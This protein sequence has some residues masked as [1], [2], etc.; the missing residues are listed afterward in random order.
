MLTTR[1]LMFT[2][3]L[4]L[5]LLFACAAEPHD[6]A[7]V[8]ADA[9]A[10]ARLPSFAATPQIAAAAATR[11]SSSARVRALT[12]TRSGLQIY[13]CEQGATGTP[14]WVLRTPLAELL[15]TARTRS[16]VEVDGRTLTSAYHYRN[17]LG[18]LAPALA[19]ATLGLS[20]ATAPVWDLSFE[21]PGA[22]GGG[23]REIVAGRVLAQDVVGTGNIPHFLIEV[24]GRAALA[25][26]DGVA[27]RAVP[28]DP[29]D[30]P[31][32]SSELMLRW[33]LVGG[34]APPAARCSASTLGEEAQVPYSADYYF[35]DN[36][37]PSL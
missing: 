26:Q 24:R 20:N 27:T 30:H 1:Q 37:P 13:R 10:S 33:N 8:S 29:Y 36:D 35:I 11:L 19:Q 4:G 22:S 14:A 18:G 21:A 3:T 2:A 28:V 32:A 9:V 16:N 15:P 34:V 31:V 6:D 25:T 23:T 5:P 7:E 12:R 17:D